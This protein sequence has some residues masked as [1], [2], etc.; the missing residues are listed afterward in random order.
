MTAWS[1]GTATLT[2]TVEDTNDDSNRIT[3]TY[4]LHEAQAAAVE[5]GITVAAAENGTIAVKAGDAEVSKAV[6]GTEIAV[7]AAPADGYELHLEAEAAL[8]S[9]PTVQ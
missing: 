3:K 4:Y 9:Y 1:A 6:E 2:L 8:L 7:T 5:Y